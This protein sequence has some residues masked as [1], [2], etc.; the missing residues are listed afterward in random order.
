MTEAAADSAVV[1]VVDDD[2]GVRESLCLLLRSVGINCESFA[3]AGAF[4]SGFRPDRVCCLI[5]DIRMPVMSGLELQQELNSRE[6]DVPII[7]ITGHGD[8]P[9]AVGAMRNGAV[10]FL[11]KP[12]R[13]RELLD[14]LEFALEHARQRIEGQN[15]R[16]EVRTRFDSLTPR[17]AEV[18]A[19]VVQGHANKIIAMDLGVSQRTVE[20]HRARVMQKMAAR[21]LAELVRLSEMLD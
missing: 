12:F 6:L 13:D 10:D 17:E 16:T 18:M 9:M 20:L 7:F 8:V 21:S 15:Q 5:A 4:L 11:T 14:R 2:R 3:S 1:Y 19:M